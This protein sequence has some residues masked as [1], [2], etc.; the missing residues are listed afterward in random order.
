MALAIP[1]WLAQTGI[2]A[3]IAGIQA[4]SQRR[5][6]RK[7]WED[8]NA[9]NTPGR[10]MDRFR[11]A[12]L[13][14]NLIYSQGNA[15]NA[16]S[17]PT[18]PKADTPDADIEGT[19]L[20]SRQRA[21]LDTQENLIEE[22]RNTELYKQQLHTAQA[23]QSI[24]DSKYKDALTNETLT[25]LGSTLEQI[26]TNIKQSQSSIAVNQAQI[27]SLL[28]TAELNK[29]KTILTQ[30]EVDAK[31][32]MILI[33]NIKYQYMK[34]NPGQTLDDPTI[35]RNIIREVKETGVALNK[36]NWR[37][38]EWLAKNHPKVY[39]I[40]VPQRYRVPTK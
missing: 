21:I 37:Y 39:N 2:K 12:G 8:M 1:T 5:W 3:G 17:M 29:A 25:L 38:S 36:L 40:M 22:Q 7:Q 9:Y 14:P 30:T 24:A 27:Q 35:A 11:R 33:Q 16:P 23:I 19:K 6:Q 28:S 26:N 20:K 32:L 4:W 31:K 15:G 34:E 13:N 10:Q 18:G